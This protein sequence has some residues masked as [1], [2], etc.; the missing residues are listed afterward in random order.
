[1]KSDWYQRL[2]EVVQ[3]ESDNETAIEKM[4]GMYSTLNS[5]DKTLLGWDEGKAGSEIHDLVSPWK[6]YFVNF[7]PQPYLNAVKC[8]LLAINGEK[9]CQVIST[10][11]LRGIERHLRESQNSDFTTVELPGLN[12]LFQTADTGAESE[13]RH[14]EETI[15]PVALETIS[16]WI[17]ERTP[18]S[19]KQ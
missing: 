19:S 18:V 7:D 14:I 4:M 12:H 15:A 16:D 2:Y 17:V 3:Q 6:R 5:Q 1:M 10:E 9:D 8:P 13:Y 11:N